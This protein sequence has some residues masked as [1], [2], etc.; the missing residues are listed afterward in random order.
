MRERERERERERKGE[1]EERRE[2]LHLGLHGDVMHT[3]ILGNK[4]YTSFVNAKEMKTKGRGK[5][6]REEKRRELV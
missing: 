6:R 2:L 4:F 5:G 3:D 1:R